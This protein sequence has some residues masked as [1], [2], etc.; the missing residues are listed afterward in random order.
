MNKI[1][2]IGLGFVGLPLAGIL[3][4]L[5]KIRYQVNGIDKSFDSKKISKKRFLKNFKDKLT[6]KKLIKNISNLQKN[7]NFSI[8]NDFENLKDSQVVVVSISFDFKINSIRNSYNLLKDLFREISLKIN[9]STL[10][11]LETTIPPGTSEK[12]IIPN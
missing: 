8:S 1:S 6:D 7:D 4:N 12:I 11:I 9:K 10:I 5:K 3:S 2:I